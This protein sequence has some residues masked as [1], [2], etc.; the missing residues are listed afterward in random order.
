MQGDDARRR[1]KVARSRAR[2]SPGRVP[3]DDG[4]GGPIR[5]HGGAVTAM[6]TLLAL[7]WPVRL[8]ALAILCFGMAAALT[9]LGFV[10]ERLFGGRRIFAMALPPGQYTR[11]LRNGLM[12]LSLL[13]IAGTFYL[14]AGWVDWSGRGSVSGLVTFAL[15]WLGFE[16]YYYLLH[17]A[18]H[19]RTLIRVHREHHR[20]HINTPLTAFSTSIP[21]CL[22]WIVGYAFVP[23]VMTGLGLPVHPSGF[24]AYLIYN[25][26]GN[27]IGH[28]NCEIFPAFAGRRSAS[29]LAH[30][31]IYHA[32]HHARYTGHYA[33]GASFMDRSFGSE[34]SDWPELHAEVLAGAAMTSLKQ[35]GRSSGQGV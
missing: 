5:H 1:G 16:V 24:L 14:G 20:S 13:T 23:L 22:G 4:V 17:R 19:T 6:E 8:A 11:E 15:C 3:G 34:W 25:F 30:P 31:I 35:R 21:E 33:F 9:A 7:S 12:F 18:M 10:F 2:A 29:W 32:L 26:S 27:V 28:V